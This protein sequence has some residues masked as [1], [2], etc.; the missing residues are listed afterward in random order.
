[1]RPRIICHM[2]SSIDGRIDGT[3][4]KNVVNGKEYEETGDA[5][6]GDAWVC[7][8]VTMQQHFAEG[9]RFEAGSSEPI[10]QY[11]SHVALKADSYA[12]AVDT[13][14]SLLWQ[15]GDLDG[16]HLICILS[17]KAP[18]EYLVYLREKGISYIAA[19]KTSVDLEKAVTVLHE[20]FGIKTLLLEGGGHINGA[21]LQASLVD[22]VSLLLAPGI[23][24]RRDVPSVFDGMSGPLQSAVALKLLS[25]QEL[26][27]GVLWIRYEVP[28]QAK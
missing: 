24:G 26:D 23:D 13:N 7:G 21:F 28:R 18:A 19:G 20:Q 15:G 8:R 12:I 27:K 4:L 14:G 10:G 3:A 22:E 1:M 17:E 16:E 2:L 11:V 5:L 9:G 25:V 6:E